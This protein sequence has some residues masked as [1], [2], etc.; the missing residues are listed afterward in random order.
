MRHSMQIAGDNHNSM[1]LVKSV[2]TLEVV[3]FHQ[4]V[5]K[6]RDQS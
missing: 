4:H 3:A 1:W 5:A 2:K 6:L